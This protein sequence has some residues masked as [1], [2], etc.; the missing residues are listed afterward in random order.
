MNITRPNSALNDKNVD[1]S[2]VDRLLEAIH[3]LV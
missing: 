1:V 3:T 2:V